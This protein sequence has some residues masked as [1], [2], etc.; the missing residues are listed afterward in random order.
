MTDSFI[1]LLLGYSTSPLQ[2]FET[3]LRII[4]GLDEDDIQLILKQY[5]ANFVT[6]HLDPGIYSTEDLQEAVYPLVH[7]ENTLQIEYDDNTM[8]TELF[9]NG[10]V[11]TFGTMRFVEKSFFK[12]FTIYTILGL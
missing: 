9:L 2:N 7:H 4:V 3:Y 11:G 10:F 8:K 1:K 12:T 5:N 6:Y